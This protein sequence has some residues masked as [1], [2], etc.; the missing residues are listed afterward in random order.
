MSDETPAAPASFDLSAALPTD[1]AMIDIV[2]PGGQPTGWKIEL[3]GPSH[4]KTIAVSDET[5]RE[6]LQKEKAIEFAQVNGRKWKTDV[7]TPDER[8]DRVVGRLVRRI[9]GWSPDPVF[10][11]VGPEP[12]TFSDSAAKA[13]FLRKDMAWAL[14]QIAEYLTSETAFTQRSATG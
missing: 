5:A 6:Q 10:R 3:A 12:I 7:E 4:P 1:T 8:A 9:V 14:N 2:Y 11:Q 13:L